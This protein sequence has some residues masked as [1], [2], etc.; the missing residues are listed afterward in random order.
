MGRVAG[1]HV[2]ENTE[3]H[4][5][6]EEFMLAAN[7]AVAELLAKAELHFLR[8]VHQAP[9]P[10]KLK[11]LDRIR[12]RA[13]AFNVESLESRFEL[14]KLLADVAGRRNNGPS[15]MRCCAA[16]SGPSTAPRKKATM[17][18]PASATATSPRRFAAIP[19]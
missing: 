1:A 7:E 9:D 8:R 17:P 4:Q 18:W 16:C 2:V 19:T 14:Q 11:A 10:R 12:R 3:S 13:W 6:I 5:I 15:T